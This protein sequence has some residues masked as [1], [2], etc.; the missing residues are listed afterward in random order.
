[1]L[2][3]RFLLI[4]IYAVSAITLVALLFWSAPYGRHKRAGWGPTLRARTAWVV[5]ESPAVAVIA[6]TALGSGPLRLV[7]LVCLVLWEMHYVYRTLVYPALM[8]SS[9]RNVPLVLAIVAMAYNA[10][11]GY[12]NGWRLFR[13]EPRYDPDWLHDPR[14]LAGVVVFLVGFFTHVWSDAL[15]RGLRRPGEDVYRVPTRGLFRFVSSPNYLGEMV[16]WFGWALAT[17]SLAGLSFAVF[18]TANLLPRA[19]SN[20]AWYRRIFA[21]Y[22]DR[23]KAVIPLIL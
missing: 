22:P 3:Y 4:G 21:D 7:P 15:L 16:Q 10:A 18:T 19:L 11:N 6:I 12:V 1:V 8:R 20:H 23:R 17:W 9:P 2:A 14:F 13:L 5:M